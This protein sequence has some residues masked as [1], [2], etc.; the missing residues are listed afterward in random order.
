M[1]DFFQGKMSCTGCGLVK[2]REKVV[3]NKNKRSTTKREKISTLILQVLILQ[4]QTA[5]NT[6]RVL[7]MT[8]AK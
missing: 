8:P 2:A 4:I 6:G 1:G 5:L 7:W 3:E